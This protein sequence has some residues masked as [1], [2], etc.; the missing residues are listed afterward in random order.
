M[1]IDLTKKQVAAVGFVQLKNADGSLM[2]DEAGKGAFARMHSPASKTWEVAN[3][4]RRRKLM[5]RVRENGGKIEAAT[6][7]PDDIVDFLTAITEEFIGVSVPLPDGD[8]T[9]KGL[10]RA[11]Y[12]NPEL[13]YIRDQMD[14]DSKDWGAYLGNLPTNSNFTSGSS[15]G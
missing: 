7:E 14:A 3:A 6:D 1:P 9:A 10:V 12:A 8:A 4:A 5:K 2:L 15:A 11:I 13:G